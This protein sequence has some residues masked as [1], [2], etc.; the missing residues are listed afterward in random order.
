MSSAFVGAF[1]LQG[2]VSTETMCDPDSP[3]RK[4]LAVQVMIAFKI[5]GMGRA[6][7]EQIERRMVW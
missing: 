3:H 5:Y 6:F 7:L 1:C 4:T 2:R